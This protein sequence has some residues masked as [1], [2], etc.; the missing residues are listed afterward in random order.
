MK[1]YTD[2]EAALDAQSASGCFRCDTGYE[3]T[4]AVCGLSLTKRLLRKKAIG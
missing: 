4:P 3:H 1:S 2:W